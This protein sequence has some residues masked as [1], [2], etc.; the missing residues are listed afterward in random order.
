M[1]LAGLLA[2]CLGLPLL[3]GPLKPISLKHE[4]AQKTAFS[5]L[6]YKPT[7]EGMGSI[8]SRG[9]RLFKHATTQ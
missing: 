2:L 9:P 1:C 4:Y 8:S 7:F 3:Y 5:T 6:D